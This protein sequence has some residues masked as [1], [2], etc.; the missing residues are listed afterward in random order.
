MDI[1]NLI[2]ELILNILVVFCCAIGVSFI[3]IV[4]L[5]L[6]I[7]DSLIFIYKKTGGILWPNKQ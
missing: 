2:K 3:S 7:Q 4:I 6:I 5:L 1:I